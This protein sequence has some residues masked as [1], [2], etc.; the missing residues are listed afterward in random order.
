[1]QIGDTLVG[2]HHRD[3]GTFSENRGYFVFDRGFLISGE[4]G[5]LRDHIPEAI[6]LVYS[7]FGE[8]GFMSREELIEENTNRVAENDG[9]GNL[10]HRGLHVQ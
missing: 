6:V 9:I 8:K 3:V 2:I 4:L 1:M 10:H 7:D 5:Q